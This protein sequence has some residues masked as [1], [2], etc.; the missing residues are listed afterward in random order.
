MVNR[1]VC[2]AQKCNTSRRGLRKLTLDRIHSLGERPLR[3][4]QFSRSNTLEKDS[5]GSECRRPGSTAFRHLFEV[6]RLQ[7][8]AVFD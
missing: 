2:A 5:K 3:H 7:V 4:S 6:R 8:R 1:G